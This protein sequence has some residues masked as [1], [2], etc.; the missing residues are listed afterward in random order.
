MYDTIT[1]RNVRVADRNRIVNVKHEIR[2]RYDFTIEIRLS[3]GGR[4][5]QSIAGA[6]RQ[7]YL[8]IFIVSLAFSQSAGDIN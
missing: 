3:C 8:R 7:S 1:V 4:N 2:L 6:T 5:I